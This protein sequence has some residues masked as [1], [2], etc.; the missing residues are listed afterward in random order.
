MISCQENF[1]FF[2][3]LLDFANIIIYF[4]DM[5]KL[6]DKSHP[7]NVHASNVNVTNLTYSEVRKTISAGFEE[8][9]S[10]LKKHHLVKRLFELSFFQ[11]FM[12]SVCYSF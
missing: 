2:F 12:P 6:A 7:M 3:T 1:F 9:I 10:A 5:S 8:Q 4:L 11:R